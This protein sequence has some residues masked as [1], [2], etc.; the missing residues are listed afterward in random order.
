MGDGMFELLGVPALLGRTFQADDFQPGRERVLVLSRRLMRS[1]VRLAAIDPGFN[2]KNVLSMTISLAGQTD[3]VG[4]KREAFYQELFHRIEALPGVQSAS[5]INH[6]PLAG[7]TWGLGISVEGRPLPAPGE[8]ISAVFRVCRPKY[9]S[10]MGMSLLRGRDFSEQD[11]LGS[12]GVA[13]IN[14]NLARRQFANED[15]IGKRLTLDDP[16]GNPEWLTIVGVV[17]DAK[18]NSW[19]SD[20]SNEIY[21]PWLQSKGYIAETGGHIAYM[22]LVIRTRTNPR[23]L[24]GAVQSAVWGL[25]Q[26][27]PV[28]SAATLEE[29]VANAVWQQRFNLILIGI[30]AA[31]ALVLAGAGIYGVT[32]YSVAQRTE[33]I[34]VRMALGARR[35][36]V[37]GLVVGQGMRLAL[38]GV[39]IGVVTALALTRVLRKL[40]YEIG[41]TDPLTFLGVSLLLI[42][43]ALLA[44]CRPA[45]RRGPIQWRR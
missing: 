3:L 23:T 17:K 19:T 6:L 26:S 24:I 7:D 21:L 4:P 16:R 42:G 22:T 9:F 5:A 15:P 30:F 8:N 13:I 37:L 36:D 31:L 29:V 38:Y 32:A 18:Q 10:T 27:A 1:F 25:N 45:G 39:G 44:C 43:I 2:P 35:A 14:Q 20:P 12:P 40:L 41:P 34:G 11:R 28:S 33:E